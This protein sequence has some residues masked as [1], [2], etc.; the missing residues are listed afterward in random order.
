M[1]N[2]GFGANAS[3]W[4]PTL[5]RGPLSNAPSGET[6]GRPPGFPRHATVRLRPVASGDVID[7]HSHVLPGLDDGAR[8]IDDSLDIVAGAAAD[9]VRVLAATPHV[10][11]DFPTTADAMERA[12]RLVRDA[13]ARTGIEVDVRGGGEIALERVEG[14]RD[15]ELAR[16]GLGG[17]PAYILLEFPYFGWPPALPALVLRLRSRGITP[18]VAHP[19]RN[20][21]VQADPERL[22]PIV[23]AGA[24]S[25]I[26]AA[27]LDGRLGRKARATALDLIDRGLGHLLASDAHT[28]EIRGI[29][30]SD[31]ASAV[32]DEE[33]AWWLTEGVPGAILRGEPPPPRPVRRRPGLFRSRSLGQ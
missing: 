12:L 13:V 19:E 21:E 33:L 5:A 7:L 29:G 18:V 14:L 27:S 20:G 4:C 28:P 30:M 8:T 11:S 32:R 26:T 25:Q 9:G 15:G 17:S 6:T 23:L 2:L 24:L 1:R 16:F 22:R 3:I 10:R 31:A